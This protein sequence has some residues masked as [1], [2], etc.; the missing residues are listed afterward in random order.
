MFKERD[1]HRTVVQLNSMMCPQK[2][3]LLC[4]IHIYAGC[5][6]MC[7]RIY[8]PF[9]YANEFVRKIGGQEETPRRTYYDLM[10][11]HRR[12]DLFV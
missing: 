12:C 2:S 4:V 7:G 5:V 3:E 10:H 1:L 11:L 8:N 6:D 9:L